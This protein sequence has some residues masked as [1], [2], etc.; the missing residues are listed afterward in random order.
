M[1]LSADT[2]ALKQTY[3]SCINICHDCVLACSR[4]IHHHHNNHTK[5]S[6]CIK[7]C[8]ECKSICETLREI[9]LSGSELAEV[10]ALACEQACLECRKE[11]RKHN[12][13]ICRN[14][15]D[16]CGKCADE[17]ERVIQARIDS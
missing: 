1:T 10:T 6:K 4:C 9:L 3:D 2:F 14:C 7:L 17:C 16:L 11:C 15:A 12:N 5:M 13:A 8:G